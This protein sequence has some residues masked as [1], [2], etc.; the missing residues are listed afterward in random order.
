MKR[1]VHGALIVI[2]LILASCVC[3]CPPVR[4][5]HSPDHLAGVVPPPCSALP[6]VVLAAL[7]HCGKKHRLVS[8]IINTCIDVM[9]F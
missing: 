5:H 1:D 9:L 3:V 4:W 8:Q 2:V 6:V 7:L